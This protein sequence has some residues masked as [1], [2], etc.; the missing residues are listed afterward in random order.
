MSVFKNRGV[1]VLAA[2]VLAGI[3]GDT[4]RA[5]D[6]VPSQLAV[7]SSAT[8]W[9]NDI[10][11]YAVVR[12]PGKAALFY[13]KNARY[14][15]DP[16]DAAK[17]VAFFQQSCT[18]PIDTFASTNQNY[19]GATKKTYL[20]ASAG[21]PASRLLVETLY[22]DGHQENSVESGMNTYTIDLYSGDVPAD[23]TL[24][25]QGAHMVSQGLENAT[26]QAYHNT[27]L[28]LGQA[29]MDYAPIQD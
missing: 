27:Y 12:Q 13:C 29:P 7:Y 15:G 19:S 14:Q 1:A 24:L 2:L 20:S 11:A 26:L 17:V 4:V 10:F 16:K 6:G 9:Q 23:S 18:S 21:A 22:A 25:F 8:V 5:A 3:A 28:L